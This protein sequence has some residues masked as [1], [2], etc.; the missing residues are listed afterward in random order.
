MRPQHAL[1]AADEGAAAHVLLHCHLP[2]ARTSRYGVF[3]GMAPK[4]HIGSLGCR[5][6]THHNADMHA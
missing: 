2:C 6:P 3:S 5:L 4:L 1:E